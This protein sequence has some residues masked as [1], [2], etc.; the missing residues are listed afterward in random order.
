V[1]RIGKAPIA[2]PAQVKTKMEDGVLTVTGPKGTLEHALRPGMTLEITDQ[3]IIVHRADD[4]R[5]TRALHGLTRSL[6]ANLVT[7]VT[8]GFTRSLDVTGVGYRSELKGSTVVLSLGYS[9]PI[10]FT[11]PEGISAT[12]DKQNQI[13]ISGCDK[14]KVGATAAKIRS[15]RSPEP[16]KGKG[17]RFTEERVRRKVGKSGGK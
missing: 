15:F 12:I 17:V 8:Q 2:L 10:N 5:K 9:H 3:T 14:Q 4:D 6:I 11:L 1:S 7:G 16:Y 13:V